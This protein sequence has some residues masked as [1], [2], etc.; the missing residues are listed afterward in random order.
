MQY[1]LINN[2]SR[3]IPPEDVWLYTPTIIVTN[4]PSKQNV[5]AN[6]VLQIGMGLKGTRKIG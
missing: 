3:R 2:N 4:R 6:N 5:K 1:K